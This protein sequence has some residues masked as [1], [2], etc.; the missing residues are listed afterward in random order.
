MQPSFKGLSFEEGFFHSQETYIHPTAIIGDQVT[1]GTNV[2]IGPYCVVIGKVT[3]GNNTRLHGH[4]TIGYPAEV[5]GLMDN[6]GTITIGEQCEIREF[7]TI[8]APRTADG[9]TSVGNYVYIMNYCHISH[10]CVV[11]DYVTMT[12]GTNLGGHTHVEHH[13]VLMANSATHQFTRV[14]QYTCLAAYSAIRQDVPPFSMYWGLPASFSGLNRVGLRRA[15]FSAET[16]NAIKHAAKLYFQ[17]KLPFAA[18][19]EAAEAEDWGAIDAVQTFLAFIEKSNRGVSRKTLAD[20]GTSSDSS[21]GTG[22]E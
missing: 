14:G 10:N 2:K 4:V 13:A 15:G 6:H 8:H 7:A 21:L 1:L 5:K 22:S 19:K 16:L 11:E 18:I 9:V 3:I 12:N 17:D 20:S